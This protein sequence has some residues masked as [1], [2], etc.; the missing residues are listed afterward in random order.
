MIGYH[1]DRLPLPTHYFSPFLSLHVVSEVF[2]CQIGIV[3]Y[4]DV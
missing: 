4:K 1:G 3:T 2:S